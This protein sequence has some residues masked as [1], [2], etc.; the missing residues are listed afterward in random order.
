MRRVEWALGAAIGTLLLVLAAAA[1]F[2]PAGAA[3]AEAPD[4]ESPVRTEVEQYDILSG[5][6]KVGH[7]RLKKM[8]V[9]DLVI[10]DTEFVAPYK[11]QDAGFETQVVYR[12]TDKP[13]PQRGKAVTRLGG[14]KL[15]EGAVEFAASGEQLTG[16][17]ETT[18]YADTD[19][20]PFETPRTVKKDVTV[21]AALVLTHPAL[22]HFGPLLLP[23]PGRIEKVAQ[24]EI[25]DDLGYPQLVGFRPDC[26]LVRKPE[27]ADG[28]SEIALER[29]FAG[30]NAVAVMKMMIDRDGK[31]VESDL[32]RFV[33]RPAR[34]EGEKPKADDEP[35]TGE[36][37]KTPEKRKGK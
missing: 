35:K 20:K 14:F 19:R 34:P 18:G 16:K 1:A 17:T 24:M 21:T 6:R 25:P 8:I 13:V 4:L 12:G 27:T 22:L 2:G 11:T 26:V 7:M 33:L 29:V 28:L 37:R 3:R 36:K 23:A 30:G 15:M 31:I 9:K 10:L 32:G 5:S